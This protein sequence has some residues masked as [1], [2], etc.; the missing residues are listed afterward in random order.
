MEVEKW[1]RRRWN[2]ARE[3]TRAAEKKKSEEKRRVWNKIDAPCRFW[4]PNRRGACPEIKKKLLLTHHVGYKA[5]NRRGVCPNF[6]F[7]PQF[8]PICHTAC[9]TSVKRPP[10]CGI[11][12][13]PRTFKNLNF[14]FLYIGQWRLILTTDVGLFIYLQKCHRVSNYMVCL[15]NR[16][17]K[18]T[19]KPIFLLV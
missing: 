7:F 8:S 16:H 11:H 13:P 10:P 3:N 6:N 18:E 15:F 4:P 2:S 17:K 9:T 19:L 1:R 5:Q 14:S 12:V